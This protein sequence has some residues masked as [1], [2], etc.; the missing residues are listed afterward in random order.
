MPFSLPA[1]SPCPG[2][3]CVT[4]EHNST[5]SASHQALGR[6]PASGV[7]AAPARTDTSGINSSL[8]TFGVRQGG[9]QS[10]HS[11]LRLEERPNNPKTG[12][13]ITIID[14]ASVSLA[15]PHQQANE[16]RYAYAGNDLS[17]T[18]S[19]NV[20]LSYNSYI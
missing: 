5:V 1:P 3:A 6:T 15:S 20:E 16:L 2:M 19:G 8:P 7:L 11:V 18:A 17:V 13:D 9:V 14:S 10:H 4:S 12:D